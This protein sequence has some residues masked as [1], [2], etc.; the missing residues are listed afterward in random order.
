VDERY[1]GDETA[2]AIHLY[3]LSPYTVPPALIRSVALVKI[4]AAR[5]NRELG[6]LDEDAAVS[7]EGACR[8]LIDI[9]DAEIV[10]EIPLD[11][12]QGGAGTSTNM[13]VNEWVAAHCPGTV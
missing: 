9:P 3:N 11:A 6:F 8:H 7:I 1:A 2:R 10:L 12:F 13:A 5:C 4:A